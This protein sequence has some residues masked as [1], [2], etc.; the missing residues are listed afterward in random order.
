MNDELVELIVDS[1]RGKNFHYFAAKRKAAVF[2]LLVV[3]STV[4]NALISSKVL[5]DFE[6]I[7]YLSMLAAICSGVVAVLKL[8]HMSSLH[9][10]IGNA[11]VSVYRDLRLL[12]ARC[13]SGLLTMVQLEKEFALLL[14]DYKKAAAM[15]S[16]APLG[17]IDNWARVLGQLGRRFSTKLFG[18]ADL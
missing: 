17:F 15:S 5:S 11:Y 6:S 14:R 18:A 4:I 16:Q 10:Q 9:V 13:N 1:K 12:R 2:T 7:R 8:G 3:A